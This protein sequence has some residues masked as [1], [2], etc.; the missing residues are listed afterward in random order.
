[1]AGRL[2][3]QSFPARTTFSK[4][5]EGIR[6]I[7]QKKMNVQDIFKNKADGRP[8]GAVLLKRE[9]F[10]KGGKGQQNG[11]VD[12]AHMRKKERTATDACRRGFLPSF[13]KGEKI[14][15]RITAAHPARSVK[16]RYWGG[17]TTTKKRRGR[18]QDTRI[19]E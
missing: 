3:R 8:K 15:C 14:V 16:H 6:I 13:R 17:L 11:R 2:M 9:Q 1:L 12:Q 7:F 5:R 4:K 18:V 10:F 19:Y